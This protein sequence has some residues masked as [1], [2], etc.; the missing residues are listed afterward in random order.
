MEPSLSVPFSTVRE[1]LA[2]AGYVVHL[3]RKYPDSSDDQYVLF[4]KRGTPM[5]GFPVSSGRVYKGHVERIKRLLSG[6]D[7]DE[8]DTQTEAS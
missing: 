2:E 1:M 7:H 4:R 8:D 6:D 5:I 3:Q